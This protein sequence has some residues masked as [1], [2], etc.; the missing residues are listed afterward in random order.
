MRIHPVIMSGGSGSRLWPLSRE[1]YPKQFLALAGEGSL[2]QQAA[3]RASR[4]ELFHA[5]TVVANA[6]HRFLIGEQLQAI[7]ARVQA[8]LLEPIARNT[9]AAVASAALHLC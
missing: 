5:V 3:Q 7:G 9:A 6:E 2:F 1:S 8:I 4:E